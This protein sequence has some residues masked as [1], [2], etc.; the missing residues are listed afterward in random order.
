MIGLIK[1]L[2]TFDNSV[3]CKIAP[4][5]APPEVLLVAASF[6]SRILVFKVGLKGLVVLWNRDE[7]FA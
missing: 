5:I 6:Y 2:G 4:V 3:F 1:R 7:P